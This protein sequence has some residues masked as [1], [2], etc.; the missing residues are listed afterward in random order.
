MFHLFM[1]IQI[2]I[3]G[4]ALAIYSAYKHFPEFIGYVG[5]HFPGQ[6]RPRKLPIG[7][8]RENALSSRDIE[9]NLI[10]TTHPDRFVINIENSGQETH[11]DILFEQDRICDDI[12]LIFITFIRTD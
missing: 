4:Q 11:Q 6:E 9:T 8:M 5:R 3:L 7:L 1:S 10:H 12:S 2:Q